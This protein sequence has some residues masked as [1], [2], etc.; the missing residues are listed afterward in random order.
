M[1][2]CFHLSSFTSRPA[3][4]PFGSR[5]CVMAP[6]ALGAQ[7]RQTGAAHP[8]QRAQPTGH[9]HIYSRGEF[10]TRQ[11]LSSE[12]ACNTAPEAA[13]R[14]RRPARRR[15]R[16][17]RSGMMSAAARRIDFCDV[18]RKRRSG[19]RTITRGCRPRRSPGRGASGRSG[20]L[21]PRRSGIVLPDSDP[22]SRRSAT[23][24]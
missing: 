13:A 17:D 2:L 19:C 14:R 23:W 24:C 4:A 1:G 15:C 18:S 12:H 11:T 3:I 22:R 8:D 9:Y 10:G 7:H 6:I 16:R 21:P 5:R 20:I